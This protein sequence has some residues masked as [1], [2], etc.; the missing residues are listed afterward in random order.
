[1]EYGAGPNTGSNPEG[2][3]QKTLVESLA[4]IWPGVRRQIKANF[5]VIFE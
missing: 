1:M 3:I 2:R 5:Q 4:P